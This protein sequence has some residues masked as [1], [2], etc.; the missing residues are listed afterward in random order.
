LIEL[1][2]H[3]EASYA[4]DWVELSSLIENSEIITKSILEK[5]LKAMN[6][7]EP[8]ITTENIF[9]T[10]EWRNQICKNYPFN[11]TGNSLQAKTTLIDALEYSFPLLLSTHNY[12]FETKIKDWNEIGDLFELYCAASTEQQ[13]GTSLLLG[14][15]L[16][17]LPEAFDDCM[18]KVCKIMNERKGLESE[19]AND[20]N[21]AGVDI[22]TYK[23]FDARKGKIVLLTQCASGKNWRLK[24]SDISLEIWVQL[25]N[26]TVTPL[27]ALTFPYAYNF[28]SPSAMADWSYY[29]TKSGLLMDR[30]RLANF[31]K[32]RSSYNLQPIGNWITSQET[33]YE[34]YIV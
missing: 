8:E 7:K 20:F 19:K 34:P 29:Q 10:L 5:Y 24:G 22:I 18:I 27:K 28:D 15:P 25:V 30:L 31:D 4:A 3:P 32:Y 2:F 26:W 11:L 6:V 12:F 13:F 16:G 17:N 14:N 1:T 9:K 21:D 23:Q 33:K